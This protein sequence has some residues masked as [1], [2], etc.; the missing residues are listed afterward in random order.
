LA[1]VANWIN[2]TFYGAALFAAVLVS[3]IVGRKRAGA[4]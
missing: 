1:G 3:T 4:T 2:D